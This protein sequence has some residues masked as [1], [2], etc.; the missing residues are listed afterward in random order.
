MKNQLLKL[1][2]LSLIASCTIYAAG[3]KIPETSVNSIALS[4]A[5]VAHSNGADAAYY[6]PANMSFMKDENTLEMGLI[7]IG[8]ESTNFKGTTSTSAI[9]IDAKSEVFYIPSTH[10]VSEKFVDTRIG[11]SIVVPGG[12]TKRWS[13]SPAKDSAEQ[14]TLEV[15]EI[16]PSVSYLVKDDLSLAL[17]ARIIYSKG[18]VKSSSSASRDMEGDGI[19]FAYNLALSYKPTAA[20]EFGVTYRSNVDLNEEGNAKLSIGNAKVYDG[21]ASVSV[22]LPALLNVAVAYTFESKTTLEFVYEKNFWSTY[23]T[24]DFN[25]VSTIPAILQPSMD[26]PVNKNWKD[27]NAYRLGITQEL[28]KLTLMV[29]F[30]ID[31]SPIPNETLSFEL[32]DS[33][34]ISVSLGGR[35][36]LNEKMEIG[37]STLYLM[38]NSRDMTH[39]SIDGT[40]ASSSTYLISTALSYKF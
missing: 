31:E 9:D 25:Y 32:P 36:K 11:L 12:L 39:D 16:N 38:K 19:D 8:L 13:D 20:L 24:L 10:F 5:N 2:S 4:A 22:P 14:F 3:Y 40:F 6:N 37:L 7:I 21:G 15:V 1:T 27:T 35:Y 33:D 18:I 34:G 29:G 23:D 28:D 30:L 26:Y 17:G